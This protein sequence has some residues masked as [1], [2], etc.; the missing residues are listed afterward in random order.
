MLTGDKV[1]TAINIG[2]S[3]NLLREDMTILRLC[4]SDNDNRQRPE[5]SSV[6]EATQGSA[7]VPNKDHLPG[8]LQETATLAID[9][10]PEMSKGAGASGDDAQKRIVVRATMTAPVEQVLEVDVCG[11]PSE[12]SIR[13]C[14]HE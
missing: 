8:G 9:L 4:V 2:H 6:G 13:R 11:V 10:D 12:Q 3:C 14:R 5:R 7:Y 1:D